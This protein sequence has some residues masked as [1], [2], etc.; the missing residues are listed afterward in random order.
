LTTGIQVMLAAT[1]AAPDSDR[2]LHGGG[3]GSAAN[4]ASGFRF[5][6]M[7]SRLPQPSLNIEP[8]KML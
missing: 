3:G 5:V 2:N 6:G 1:S 4:G 8:M 7:I